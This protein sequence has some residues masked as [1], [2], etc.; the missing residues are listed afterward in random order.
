MPEKRV[1][2]K[3]LIKERKIEM[4]LLQETK[5]HS[6]SREMV[7]SVWLGSNFE[8]SSVDS[9]GNSGG[10]LCIWNLDMFSLESCCSNKNFIIL[11]GIFNSMFRC[12]IISIYA[13]TDVGERGKMWESLIRIKP[14]FV[15]CWCLG[16]DF[17]E[18]RSL[19]E[20][21]GSARRDRGMMEFNKFVEDMVVFDPHMLGRKFTWC[22]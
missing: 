8:F 19:G 12:A 9:M 2:I 4:V 3:K 17:N 15:D 21:I 18:I 1:K 5:R 14:N 13:L 22:K 10:L 7:Q 20:R 16:G 11:S 6:M